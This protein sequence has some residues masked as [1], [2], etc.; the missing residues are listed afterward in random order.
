MGQPG[1]LGL[2]GSGRRLE[3]SHLLLGSQYSEQLCLC[4]PLGGTIFSSGR[5]D[6]PLQHVAL[7]P[8]IE[9][10]PWGLCVNP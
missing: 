5:S 2:V 1:A 7:G 6:L 10:N 9:G 3:G 8:L 4:R